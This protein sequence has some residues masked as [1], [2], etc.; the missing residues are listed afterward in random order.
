MKNRFLY[1]Y[2]G[3]LLAVFFVAGCSTKTKLTKVET[4]SIS[5][6]ST[7]N[8]SEDQTIAAYIEPY[9]KKMDAEMNAVLIVSENAMVKDLPESSLG[10]MVSDI[11]LQKASEKYKAKF[12]KNVDMVMLNNGGLRTSFPKGEITKGKVFELMPFE[13]E[14]VV[15]T[16]S[17]EKTQQL[18]DYVARAKGMPMAG[19]KMG[20]KDTIPTN[21]LIG[22]VAFDNT[23]TYTVATSDYLSAGG[24]KM[25]FF[26]NPIKIDNV[27]YKL[28]DALID[29]MVE[30]NAKGNKLNFKKDGRIRIEK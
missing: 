20:I 24:D 28:R 27:G 26:N 25:K 17:G 22:G 30:E 2:L 13:N 19:I 9:K 11:V 4:S 23:K 16:L 5:F 15:L 18:F 29:Y 6:K 10:N 1:R 3:L 21:I 7:E 8:G 14:I 12:G